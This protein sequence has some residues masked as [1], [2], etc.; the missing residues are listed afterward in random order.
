MRRAGLGLRIGGGEET[1]AWI[2]RLGVENWVG[3]M[4][5]G[6]S[7]G[8][9]E[10]TGISWWGAGWRSRGEYAAGGSMRLGRKG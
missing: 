5:A 7:S 3:G 10:E 9:G 8:R 4:C 2:P 6:R 1:S